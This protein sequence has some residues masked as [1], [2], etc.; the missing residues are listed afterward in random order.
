LNICLHEEEQSISS[1]I[2]FA[3]ERHIFYKT[4]F[5]GLATPNSLSVSPK[6]G[7]FRVPFHFNLSLC[8]ISRLS[9]ANRLRR[10]LGSGRQWSGG[11]LSVRRGRSRTGLVGCSGRVAGASRDTPGI[12]WAR[13]IEGTAG[14]IWTGR[15]GRLYGRSSRSR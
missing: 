10:R 13:W 7:N 9:V 14:R 6:A 5:F 3:V 1:H 12:A 15:R 8:L 4:V 11:K 2:A